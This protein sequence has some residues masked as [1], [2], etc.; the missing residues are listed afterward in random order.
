MPRPFPSLHRCFRSILAALPAL[1]LPAITHAAP[2]VAPPSL[3]TPPIGVYARG[4]VAGAHAIGAPQGVELGF[5]VA[6]TGGVG[7]VPKS[8]ISLGV[9][10]PFVLLTTGR[11]TDSRFVPRQTSV[12]TAFLA[13]VGV[14]PLDSDAPGARR[15]TGLALRGGVGP[16]VTGDLVRVGLRAAIAWDFAVSDRLRI[17]PE[18][19]YLHVFQP[20]DAVRPED[21]RV[22]GLGIALAV[23]PGP[24]PV[25]P[26]SGGDQDHDG[27]LD[28]ED[29]CP[30]EPGLRTKD[31]KTNG[32]P[33]RDRDHDGIMDARDACPDEPGIASDD[34]KKNGCP[35][36]DRDEDGILDAEDACPVDPGV[37][38]KDPKTN[39]CP[40][41]DRDGDTI[42][43]DDD[44]CPDVW[45]VPTDDP[46]TNGCPRAQGS[47][48][49]EA[50]RLILD[51]RI[52]FDL[53]S[54]RVRHASWPIVEKVAKF[55]LDNPDIQELTVE[56][57]ADALGSEE[58]NLKLSKDRA[59]A[60]KQLLIKFGLAESRV[61]AEGFGRSR[62]RVQ[63]AH[64]E[65][66]NRRVEFWVTRSRSLKGDATPTA[67]TDKP[68]SSPSK[69]NL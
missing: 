16:V 24:R 5:G 34:P 37:R 44:A 22:L 50:D 47:I 42:F 39:G 21:G 20:N 62:L 57:H 31:P 23:A 2:S 59:N 68:A 12:A 8:G 15:L 18:I 69:G 43:D 45:G 19:S 66:Q 63:T 32:C 64:A 49:L 53:D 36:R 58:H 41:K 61:Q 65:Q 33:L 4:S 11:A 14:H 40:R 25:A 7:L 1:V 51:D 55:V 6:A 3:A 52:L 9:D 35:V 30:T 54:P 38:T 27:V 60:V 10:V 13:T 48:H 46:K 28:A 56:G 17:G 67:P 26:V 29:A